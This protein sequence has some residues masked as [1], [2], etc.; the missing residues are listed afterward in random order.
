MRVLRRTRPPV[1]ALLIATAALGTAFGAL[2]LTG[3]GPGTAPFGAH[4]SAPPPQ[5]ATRL[6][7]VP[8]TACPSSAVPAPTS[9]GDRFP[10]LT[11]T[12]LGGGP[13]VRMD[14]FQRAT[15]VNLWASWCGPCRDEMPRLRDSAARLGS[16]AVFLG[17]DVK[18]DAQSARAFL[19][20][21]SVGYA[22]VVDPQ[23]KLLAALHL[24]GIPATYVLDSRG[25]I[26]YR[27]VGELRARD[28]AGLEAAAR[29]A[30]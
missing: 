15:V 3:T 17:V 25:Y 26:V 8:L 11:L 7:E 16:G 21:L 19:N 18:D 5:I 22:Q 29:A 23:G 12:C 6:P 13:D 4:G 20:A 10:R 28:I 30:Y 1:V 24:P 2:A 27:H 9:S 14:G